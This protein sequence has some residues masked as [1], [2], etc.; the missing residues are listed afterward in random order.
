MSASHV[1][2]P[3]L[4]SA[5][6][7]A[8]IAHAGRILLIGACTVTALRLEDWGPGPMFGAFIFTMF[9]LWPILWLGKRIA[10]PPADT[11]L[12]L[13]PRPPILFLRS[14]RED[15]MHRDEHDIGDFISREEGFAFRFVPYL[16]KVYKLRMLLRIYMGVYELSL[17]EELARYFRRLGPFVAIGRPGERLPTVGAARLY[18]SDDEWQAEVEA[19]IRAA[20]VI[21]WQ[22][23]P[24]EGT[25][26]EFAK[27][28]EMV[29]P[30]RI[31]L[32]VP[33]PMSRPAEY[34]A[35]R[36]RA[37]RVLGTRFPERV[38]HA[39]LISFDEHRTPRFIGYEQHDDASAFFRSSRLDLESTLE[40]FT[41]RL[42]AV[43]SV[44]GGRA[45]AG[46]SRSL[47]QK[48]WR[49]GPLLNA[50][51][52]LSWL[53]LVPV[54]LVA[55]ENTL[56]ERARQCDTLLRTAVRSS[57]DVRDGRPA[58]ALA[59]FPEANLIARSHPSLTCDGISARERQA[60]LQT[61]LREQLAAALPT[62]GARADSGSVATREI[63][64]LVESLGTPE[65]RQWWR[66]EGAAIKER[67]RARSYV[68]DFTYPPGVNVKDLFGLSGLQ[69]FEEALRDSLS[70]R[71]D[72]EVNLV[73]RAAVGPGA[74]T[75]SWGACRCAS[76]S[77]A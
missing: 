15:G 23:G 51:L 66:A 65:Q 21:V 28:F 17:E 18:V 12:R 24:T 1:R 72:P 53:V 11:A 5:V 31:L 67:V 43:D 4:Q 22:A 68:V 39:N 60:T 13:D 20:Q 52:A 62:L 27:L 14:F 49:T 8:V 35:F 16:D 45:A 7:G 74:P 57:E 63:A 50:G 6:L 26:W 48:A 19:L 70:A 37:E 40:P 69:R 3:A 41:Q 54:G 75:A 9:A 58:P 30:R 59:A 32:V 25:W 10:T 36:D 44:R 64:A 77:R 42:V 76:R 55:R 61:A 47:G 46:P 33:N 71:R 2:Q 73:S 29:D 34:A 56:Q 38:M